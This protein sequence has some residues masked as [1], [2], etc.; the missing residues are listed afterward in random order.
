M[1]VSDFFVVR[2]GCDSLRRKLQEEGL[3]PLVARVLSARNV[4]A[5][6]DVVPPLSSLPPPS[7]LPGMESLCDILADAI[8]NEKTICVVGDYDADGMCATA[9]AVDGLRQLGAKTEWRI[10]GRLRHGY[11]LHKEIAED[12]FAAGA[13]VLLTVDNG[14]SAVDAVARAKELGMKV[15]VTDHHLP[16]PILPEADCIV[17]PRLG[18]DDSAM[19][20][21][22]GAGVAFYA[23]AALR[24]RLDSP[25]EMNRF[26]D[27][28]AAGT[29]ADC[30]PMDA[31]NRAL[32]GGGLLQIRRGAARPGI[33]AIAR[34]GRPDL[35]NFSCRDISHSVAP[36]INAAG[37]LDE[38][39]VA[40]RCLLAENKRQA[41]RAAAQ[42]SEMNDRRKE[43]VGEMM[44]QIVAPLPS[45]ESIV[46]SNPECPPGVTGLVAGRLA[47]LYGRPAVAFAKVNDV[48]RGSGRTPPGR[49]LYQLVKRAAKAGGVVAFGGHRQAVGVTVREV[50]PFARAFEKCCRSDKS[51]NGEL[52]HREVDET[53]P[54]SEITKEA[55]ECLNAMVWG[56]GFA[57]PM[58]AGA[59]SVSAKRTIGREHSAMR[60]RG[61]GLDLP[62]LA[63]FRRE[64]A[65]EI[66]ATFSL[67]VDSYTHRPTAVIETVLA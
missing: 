34:T 6:R 58:F 5:A 18:A 22:T 29:I 44:A 60:L 51:E 54:S 57:R 19:A 3:P 48:W 12:A 40:M 10:P 47:D 1:S 16:P 55:V 35:A 61:E 37:R 25:M 59:F 31:T 43:I 63:F 15:C 13:S 66:I 33:A 2:R 30:A 20:N 21:I 46:E 32:V 56:E 62:A 67:S 49:N 45:A 64:I 27:L 26:L 39:E 14:V 38:S 50:E 53:P 8:R 42:L 28:V 11:G 65:D 9:L 17:N 4:S 24:R 41:S 52:S 7:A 36:R 23:V